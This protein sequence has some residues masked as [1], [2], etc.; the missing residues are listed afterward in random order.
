MV[1]QAQLPCESTSFFKPCSQPVHDGS[2]RLC[3]DWDLAAQPSVGLLLYLLT[4]PLASGMGGGCLPCG[5]NFIPR[6]W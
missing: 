6:G 5:N 3:L 2:E 4:S 1:G